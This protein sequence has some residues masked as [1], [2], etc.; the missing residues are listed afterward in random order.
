MSYPPPPPPHDPNAAGP[1]HPGGGFGPPPNVN[2][3]QP[4]GGYGYPGPTSAPSVPGGPPPDAPGGYPPPPG[5]GNGGKIAAIIVAVA[6][7]L[8]GLIIGGVLLFGSGDKDDSADGPDDKPATTQPEGP[9]E[10]PSPSTDPDAEGSTEPSSPPATDTPSPTPNEV[11]YVVLKPGTC[12]DHPGLSSHVTQVK[13]VSCNGPHDGEVIAN[14]TITGTY[15]TQ[16]DLQKEALR[17]CEADARKRLSTMPGQAQDYFYYA[18]FPTLDTYR[19]GKD[20]VTCS[21][22]RTDTVDG[23]DLTEPLP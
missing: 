15:A 16:D 4:A 2:Q 9:T 21:L 23:P 3:P 11:L 22:T 1:S 17:L 14:E 18:I 19:D 8:G 5:G 12:F 20:T 6:V 10:E 13:T 7:V